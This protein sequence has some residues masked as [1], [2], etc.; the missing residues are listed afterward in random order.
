MEVRD[1]VIGV[2]QMDVGR[3]EAERQ[4]GETADAEHRRNAS[5]KSIACLKRIDPPQSDRKSAARITTDGSR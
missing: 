4:P 1:H 5:A 2:V 3:R